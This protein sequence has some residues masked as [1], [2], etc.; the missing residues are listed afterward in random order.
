MPNPYETWGKYSPG[1]VVIFPKY[2]KNWAKIVYFLVGHSDFKISFLIK[3]RLYLSDKLRRYYRTRTWSAFELRSSLRAMWQSNGRS[4]WSLSLGD[5]KIAALGMVSGFHLHPQCLPHC[6]DLEI[7][8]VNPTR[9]FS[10]SLDSVL[11]RVGRSNY[12]GPKSSL[13]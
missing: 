8:V 12:R 5:G 3:L 2:H 4:Y 1:E 10:L 11:V 7:D 9:F 6:R 13:V